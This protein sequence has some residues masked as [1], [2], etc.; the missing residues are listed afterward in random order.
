MWNFILTRFLLIILFVTGVFFQLFSAEIKITGNGV[1]IVDGDT[2]PSSIDFTSFGGISVASGSI[3]KEFNITSTLG[4]IYLTGDPNVSIIGAHESDFEV[5]TQPNGTIPMDRETFFIITFNPSGE[6]LRTA[7][8]T[9]SNNDADE[10]P[11]DFAIQGTGLVGPTP[12][13]KVTG[14]STEIYDGDHSP[15]TSDDTDFSTVLVDGG[16]NVN[17]FTISNSGSAVLNLD[18]SPIVSVT[19]EH[20]SDFSL[21]SAPS[22]TVAT[23][24]NTTFEITFNPSGRGIRNAEISI[25]NNDFD[26]DPYNFDVSGVGEGQE[27]NVT[28]NGQS[29]VNGDATPSISD[30]TDFG[31]VDINNGSRFHTFTIE[32]EGDLNLSVDTVIISG[33]H[34]ADFSVTSEPDELVSRFSSTNFIVRFDPSGLGTRSASIT[35]HNN[36]GNEN[37]YVFDI[38]GSSAVSPV[39]TTQAA[40]EIATTTATGNGDITNLGDPQSTQHG[41]CWSTSINPTT[42][43]NLTTE[44]APLATGAFTSDITGLTSDVTYHYRSY[45]SSEA[46]TFYGEDVTFKSIDIDPPVLISS[47]PTGESTNVYLSANIELTFDDN[48]VAGTGNITI[49]HSIDNSIFEEIAVN[50]AKVTISSTE[51]TIN[52]NGNFASGVDYYIEIDNTALDD[53]DGNSFAGISGNSTL[54]FTTV[55]VLIN[56]VVTDPQQD[57]S[58]N[59]FDGTIGAGSVNGGTDEWLELLIKSDSI[60]FTGWSIELLDGT[61]FSGDLTNSGAF[62]VSI[63]IGI[64]SFVNTN[65]GDYLVLGN[66]DGTGAMNYTGLTINLKDPGGIIVDQV[67]IGSGAPSGNATGVDDESVQRFSN[68]LD[69]NND[70]NDFTL[71]KASIGI[72]NTGPSVTLSLSESTIVEDGGN[73]TISATLSAASSQDVTVTIEANATSTAATEDYSFSSTTIFISSGNTIGSATITAVNDTKDETDET[74]I[75]DITEVTNGTEA[76]T[77][78]DTVTIT[79]D[80]IAPSVA[81]TASSQSSTDETGTLIITAQLSEV[82]G[83]DVTVPFTVNGSGTATGGGTDYSIE[84]SPIIITKGNLNE[85]I[86]VTISADDLDEDDETIFVEMGTPTNASLGVVTNDTLTITDDDPL[87]TVTISG[88]TADEGDGTIQLFTVELS[89]VSGRDVSVSYSSSSGTAISGED[90]THTEGLITIPAGQQSETIE[91]EILD[92]NLDEN[93]EDL[94]MELESPTNATLGN[95]NTSASISDDDDSPSVSFTIASQSSTGESGELTIIV[96]LSELSGRNVTVPFSVNGSATGGG[97]DYS[98]TAS[99]VI[100]LAGNVS[101]VLTITIATDVLDEYDETVVVEMETPTNATLGATTSHTA[102]ITDDDDSPTV[103]FTIDSQSSNNESGIMVISTQLSE[104][105]GRDVTVPFSANSSSSAI[106]GGTDYSITESPSSIAE[107]DLNGTI[108]ISIVADEIAECDETVIIDMGIPTNAIQG[109]IIKHTATI[110]DTTPPTMICRNVTV[111]LDASGEGSITVNDIDNGSS[112]GCD[113]DTMILSET[114]YTCNDVGSNFVTLT[115]T[116][117]NGN[118]ASCIANVQ[119][120]DNTPPTA[121]CNNLTVHL[122]EFGAGSVSVSEIDNGSS[123]NCEIDT[124]VLSVTDFTCTE[125]GSNLITMTVFD[126]GGNSSTC[127]STIIVED[128]VSPFALCRDTILHLDNG[129]NASISAADIGNLSNDACGI[130]SMLLS[131]IDFNCSDVGIYYDTLRVSDVNGNTSICISKVTVLDTVAPVAL[132]NDTTLHLDINGSVSIT[133]ESLDAGSDDACGIQSIALGKTDFN[134]SNLGINSDTLTII[135]VNGN[136]SFCVSTITIEDTVPPVALCND[137]T[138]F[139]DAEGVVSIDSAGL[140]DGSIDECISSIHLSHTFFTCNEFGEN[141]VVTTVSDASGNV[142]NCNSVITVL[143]TTKPVIVCNSIDILLFDDGRYVL[144]DEDVEALSFG[145]L[146]NASDCEEL[147]ISAYPQAFKCTDIYEETWIDVTATDLSGNESTCRVEVTVND[148]NPL[149]VDAVDSVQVEVDAGVCTT[150]ITYPVFVSSAC[151]TC[152]QTAGLG[153][154][155]DFPLGVT[156]ETWTGTNSSDETVEVSFVVE[157]TTANAVPTVAAVTDTTVLEDAAVVVVMLDGLSP[158]IDCDSQTVV[159]TAMGM[160]AALVSGIAVDYTAPD[161]TGTVSLTLAPDMSGTDTI[162]VYVEDSAGDTTSVMFV[163]TVTAVNDLPTIDAIADVEVDEDTPMATVMLSGI[164]SGAANE[165]Q[166]LTVTAMGGNVALV[167]DVA[168]TYTSAD[169]TGT[170]ELTIVPLMSGTD[171][172]T[173]TVSDSVDTVTETFVLTVVD[174]NHAPVVVLPVDDQSVNAS[175]ELAVSVDGVFDDVD[176]DS[177]T[178]MAMM[179]GDSVWMPLAATTFSYTPMIADTGCVMFVVKATDPDG[180]MAMDTFEVCVLGYPTAIN[181]IDAG[182]LEVTMYPNPTRGMVTMDLNS[183]SVYDVELA[184]MDITGR[185]ILRQQYSAAGTISFDMSNQVSGMYFVQL[186]VD[187]KQIVKK[188]VLDR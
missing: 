166:T 135:D 162:T 55:D 128:T 147:V 15:D 129:G 120:E 82:S 100:I 122:D 25:S 174:V 102:T 48:I 133:T 108:N 187:G 39:V 65:S 52:P 182:S 38:E 161:S 176:G 146:D 73:S 101:K 42:G 31:Y 163:V 2:E 12:E 160:N 79:D 170:L 127:T 21:T 59:N 50:D 153:A 92:D 69:T 29:I 141:K 177:L 171:T 76:G 167:S 20:A 94:Y 149:W 105:S 91:V 17:I 173:V 125:I 136:L 157:V 156:V 1:E 104:L 93:T 19:G 103:T 137:T 3:T 169:S 63:Y 49:K 58:T 37:P 168:V 154:E 179:V 144:K 117:N 97:T 164:S 172:I 60:D 46:G 10:D 8:V 32:N 40:T 188:L 180:A 119:V 36:D 152:E 45:A 158:G 151:V 84:V 61:D 181:S 80:D 99:P 83:K 41:V 134:C 126:V 71:G 107:G 183:S 33:T 142:S 4:T 74:V 44:G 175:Y 66:P 165:V 68:G 143:D 72:A 138:L 27:I 88:G 109:T 78:Q 148:E 140:D 106:G 14:N 64:G 159:V 51:V 16:T 34:A 145:T 118:F 86:L 35:I 132:C 43:D 54:N 57:W 114:N 98:I 81:F 115:A 22:S 89:E 23:S 30:D 5:T 77:Q 96:E 62:D 155:G 85:E 13:M 56:E 11:Y 87:P 116:S 112:H 185:M 6:G 139:L 18:G 47:L 110:L 124:M 111:L 131:K 53:D 24:S 150:V 26:E 70:A 75:V 113:I 95:Q 121:S 178:L 28:G 130:F 67:L 186:G 184:V 7:T 90:F 9:I 123:D